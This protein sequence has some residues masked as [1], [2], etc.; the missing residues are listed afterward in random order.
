MVQLEVFHSSLKQGRSLHPKG[1]SF[2]TGMQPSVNH[3]FVFGQF[4]ALQLFS[5]WCSA[6]RTHPFGPLFYFAR[7]GMVHAVTTPKSACSVTL[8]LTTLNT[9]EQHAPSSQQK[10][11]ACIF[12]AKPHLEFIK[13]RGPCGVLTLCSWTS[14]W[15]SKELPLWDGLIDSICMVIMLSTDYRHHGMFSPKMDLQLNSNQPEK[16]SPWTYFT[17]H[18][19]AVPTGMANHAFTIP[20]NCPA[21]ARISAPKPECSAA[22]LYKSLVEEAVSGLL[23]KW[24]RAS[25]DPNIEFSRQKR[26]I[27]VLTLPKPSGVQSR[28]EI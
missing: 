18:G 20:S 14:P 4:Q 25:K 10:L 11:A 2:W 21:V 15:W 16:E 6:S 19:K 28:S 24:M 7:S 22:F 3:V 1:L 27:V 8:R 5:S 23:P 26:N 17:T 13:L 9:C 12:D